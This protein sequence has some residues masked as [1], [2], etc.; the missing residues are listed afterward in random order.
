MMTISEA[1][2]RDFTR[3]LEANRLIVTSTMAD[4]RRLISE[5][6]KH[7]VTSAVPAQVTVVK[8]HRGDDLLF[9]DSTPEDESQQSPDI[10]LG[11]RDEL[12]HLTVEDAFQ[13]WDVSCDSAGRVVVIIPASA[14]RPKLPDT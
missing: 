4:R 14:T 7:Q 6:I 8:F 2:A 10:V 11:L 5:Y 9:L 13:G 12:V 1:A 3:L